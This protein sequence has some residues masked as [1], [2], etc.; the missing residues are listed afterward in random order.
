MCVTVPNWTGPETD[1]DCTGLKW[2]EGKED[3]E[4]QEEEQEQRLDWTG[5]DWIELYRTGASCT[6]L[7]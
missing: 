4:E 3:E 1:I 2:M 7:R 5:L 6:G